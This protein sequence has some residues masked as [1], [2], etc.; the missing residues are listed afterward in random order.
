MLNIKNNCKHIWNDYLKYLQYAFWK[1]E[2]FGIFQNTIV[3][4]V[5]NNVLFFKKSKIIGFQHFTW[6]FDLLRCSIKIIFYLFTNLFIYIYLFIVLF[7]SEIW[8]YSDLISKC[9]ISERKAIYILNWIT[10]ICEKIMERVLKDIHALLMSVLSTI[11]HNGNRS[12]LLK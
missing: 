7:Y 12:V 4:V 3:I 10:K 8:I 11:K 9:N 5:K 6:M 1:L 2:E